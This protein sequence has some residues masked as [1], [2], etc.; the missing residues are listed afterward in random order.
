MMASTSAWLRPGTDWAASLWS[1]STTCLRRG[2]MRWYRER[3]PTT[4]S[5]LSRMG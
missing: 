5:S 4:F 2:L 3:V 1:T